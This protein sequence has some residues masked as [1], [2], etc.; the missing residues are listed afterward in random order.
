[1]SDIIDIN[2]TPTVEQIE[3]AVTENL[4]TV[5]VNT[6]SGGIPNL[7]TVLDGGNSSTTNIVIQTINE[8]ALSGYSENEIASVSN[9][10]ASNTNNI[11][12]FKK[13]SVLK[14][15]ITHEGK[16][17]GASATESNQMVTLGQLESTAIPYTGTTQPITGD[18]EFGESV[19]LKY[20]GETYSSFIN[21]E[22]GG[23][24]FQGTNG[25]LE[26]YG[27]NINQSGEFTFN[28]DVP[29]SKGIGSNQ[30]HSANITD[31][32]YTQKN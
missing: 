28:S 32:D 14:S 13:G 11:S 2:V 25:S 4:T 15:A 3:I 18:L 1:M 24:N 26:N 22:D 12:E 23:V 29:T 27:F 19:K 5:N 21:F 30:D 7:Q 10:G 9:I 8:N 6:V 17:I 20:V 16:I 31:L